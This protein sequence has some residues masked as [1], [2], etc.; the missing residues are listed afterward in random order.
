MFYSTQDGKRIN[1]KIFEDIEAE[2]ADIFDQLD[3]N[4]DNQNLNQSIGNLTLK[5][6]D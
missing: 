5:K 2:V 6:K 1:E 4:V 3:E